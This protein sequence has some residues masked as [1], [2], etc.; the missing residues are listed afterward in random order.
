MLAAK[1]DKELMSTDHGVHE[2]EIYGPK[3]S[4][5]NL[6]HDRANSTNV[7]GGPSAPAR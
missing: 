7:G 3:F 5:R 2:R 4:A 1:K 6:K